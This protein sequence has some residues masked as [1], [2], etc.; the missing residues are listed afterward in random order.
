MRH[1]VLF[2][3]LNRTHLAKMAN[4]NEATPAKRPRVEVSD[5]TDGRVMGVANRGYDVLYR[6]PTPKCWVGEYTLSTEIFPD[7]FDKLKKLDFKKKYAFR[8]R[9]WEIF[10]NAKNTDAEV[11]KR[12]PTYFPNARAFLTIEYFHGR[13][14]IH[15]AT[16]KDVRIVGGQSLD[17]A[18][19]VNA[20]FFVLKPRTPLLC[21]NY[22][23]DTEKFWN[24]YTIEEFHRDRHD[25]GHLTRHVGHTFQIVPQTCCNK[26]E[27]IFIGPEST[28]QNM[29]DELTSYKPKQIN[30][31]TVNEPH[32]IS[33]DVCRA[34]P[35]NTCWGNTRKSRDATKLRGP[36]KAV[37]REDDSTKQ[38][39]DEYITFTRENTRD[40]IPP[41]LLAVIPNEGA[42]GTQQNGYLTYS[43]T[44]EIKFRLTFDAGARTVG[45]APEQTTLQGVRAPYYLVKPVNTLSDTFVSKLQELYYDVEPEMYF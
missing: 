41:F 24:N 5:E 28:S 8:Y 38:I 23:H 33:Y 17:E 1:S 14:N 29:F 40:A 9:S 3:K 10:Q 32:M 45:E 19:A 36:Y 26:K 6:T 39:W 15:G 34:M 2:W 16:K 44:Y 35:Y 30:I 43:M 18:Q 20:P 21:S 7:G 13:L 37:Y 27:M 42:D 22:N 4:N 12:L 31:G 11:L 25:S